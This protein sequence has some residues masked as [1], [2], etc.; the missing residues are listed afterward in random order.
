MKWSHL[1]VVLLVVLAACPGKKGDHTPRAGSGSG[2]GTGTGAGTGSANPALL[3]PAPPLPTPARNMPP[4]PSLSISPEEVMLGELLFFDPRLSVDG[5]TTCATCH[6]PDRDWSGTARQLTA[7]GTANVRRPLPLSDVAWRKD[8]N[9]DGRYP[10]L[11]RLLTVHFRGQLGTDPAAVIT[12][13][14]AIPLYRAYFS[15][16]YGEPPDGGRMLIA[17]GAFVATRYSAP[18]PW[19]AVEPGTAPTPGQAGTPETRGYQLFTGKA[20]CAHCHMPP[21]YTD[22][23]FHRL[24]LIK[25]PDEGRGKVEPGLR[26]AFKTPHLRGA[27]LRPAFFHDGSVTTLDEAIDWHLTGGTG[28]GADKTIIDLPA[29]TL[30]ATERADLIAFVRA[31]SADKPTPYPRPLLPQ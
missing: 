22:Q 19:D 26:G 20:Q 29:V 14:A 7:T 24:G 17:I 3:A 1:S 28:Q 30:S 23:L 21:L 11:A 9:W 6:D 13:I 15:R 18:A 8:L 5:K 31:L 10:T 27:A 25:T 2:S 16:A 12:K 4:V